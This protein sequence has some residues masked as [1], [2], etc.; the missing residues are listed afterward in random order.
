[1]T[2]P[3][4]MM[5]VVLAYLVIGVALVSWAVV[6]FRGRITRPSPMLAGV[7]WLA[8][9]GLLLYPFLPGR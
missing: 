2:T 7:F 5:W 9:T 3:P 8:M 4:H 1:V 6:H